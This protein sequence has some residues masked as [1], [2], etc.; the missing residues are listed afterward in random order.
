MSPEG[1]D[2][3]YEFERLKQS[4]SSV[5]FS[6]QTQETIFGIISAVLLLG[7]ISYIKVGKIYSRATIAWL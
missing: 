7:N 6:Q 2:E 1:V 5:G 4:M 3:I